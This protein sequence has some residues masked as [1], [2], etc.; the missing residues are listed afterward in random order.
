M[1]ADELKKKSEELAEMAEKA[2]RLEKALEKAQDAEY[3]VEVAIDVMKEFLS[4]PHGWASANW[5]DAVSELEA[6]LEQL[7]EQ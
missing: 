4:E 3:Y 1:N 5:G 7:G 6:M 2:K